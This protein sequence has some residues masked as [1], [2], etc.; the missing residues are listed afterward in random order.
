MTSAGRRFETS[1]NT[2][3]CSVPR[4]A[5]TS[6]LIARATSSRG[7]SSGGRRLL[8]WSSYQRSASSSVVAYL[9][10]NTSGMYLNIK[11]SPR[12]FVRTPPS[13]RTDS[14]TRMPR[15]DGGQTIPVGWNWRNSISLRFA[16]VLSA[17]AWP[18]PVPSQEFDV[19]LNALPTPPVAITTAGASKRISSP[20]SR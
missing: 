9:S 8:S 15:T 7:S 18:S 12:L 20:F 13:P 3:P 11:R 1:R 5:L 14:V 17:S 2:P 10:L 4:P 6:E 16:P 19:I